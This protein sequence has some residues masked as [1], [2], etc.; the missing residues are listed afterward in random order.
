MRRIAAVVFLLAG[1]A[2]A[3]PVRHVHGQLA[4]Q[5][6]V[7][8]VPVLYD[9]ATVECTLSGTWVGT[10]T[11]RTATTGAATG[12][13]WATVVTPD[14]TAS[15]TT[16][17]NGAF[18]FRVSGVAGLQVKFTTRSS[19][20]VVVDCQPSSGAPPNTPSTVAT[21]QDVNLIKINGT[22]VSSTNPLPAGGVT[23][24][25]VVAPRFCEKTIAFTTQSTT[26]IVKQI[27]EVALQHIYICGWILHASTATTGTS[28]TWYSGSGA[29]CGGG[30]NAA[31]GGPIIGTTPTSAPAT[32][33]SVYGPTGTALR[34]TLAAGDALCTK[35]AS[36]SNATTL[37]GTI[38]YTQN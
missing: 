3:L 14:R 32:P 25:G 12:D 24:D 36:V 22:A 37:S 8:A 2:A 13:N 15:A 28:L 29:N 19:G 27:N 17:S 26:S 6:D 38:F 20:T 5:N 33:N 9:D 18:T 4:A 11:F 34:M 23:G 35:Q 1:A 7:V 16:T 30:S 31:I 10:N 21:A